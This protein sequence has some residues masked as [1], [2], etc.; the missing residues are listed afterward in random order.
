M[1]ITNM[2]VIVRTS[3]GD[4]FPVAMDKNTLKLIND[5]LTKVG[6]AVKAPP[7]KMLIGIDGK[8]LV[9]PATSIPIIPKRVNFDWETAYAPIS[10]DEEKELLSQII[11]EYNVVD[12]V[13]NDDK[14]M[15]IDP[16][17]GGVE[18]EATDNS[19][20][21]VI[22]FKPCIDKS[23]EKEVDPLNPFNM[24]LE[25]EGRANVDLEVHVEDKEVPVEKKDVTVTPDPIPIIGGCN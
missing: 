25:A 9:R 24:Q 16:V 14:G 8:P 6:L 10:V 2:G 5:I 18:V 15:P 20:D 1:N 12:S 23:K 22:P 21:K 4:T 3:R 11:A 17:L 13:I 19:T 7:G